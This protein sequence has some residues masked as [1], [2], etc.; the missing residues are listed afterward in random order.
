MK[1]RKNKFL[2]SI[3][4][5]LLVFLFLNSTAWYRLKLADYYWD[6]KNYLKSA[7]LYEKVFR[8]NR[9]LSSSNRVYGRDLKLIGYRS[10]IQYQKKG[11]LSKAKNIFFFISE[12]DQDYKDIKLRM[13]QINL[14]KA[15]ELLLQEEYMQAFKKV[16]YNTGLIDE[17]DK[18]VNLLILAVSYAKLGDWPQAVESF[19]KIFKR[20]P[21]QFYSDDKYLNKQAK[22]LMLKDILHPVLIDNFDVLEK[23]TYHEIKEMLN[24]KDIDIKYT[25]PKSWIPSFLDVV[26]KSA[27]IESG[28]YS[29]IILKG[30]DISKNKRGFNIAVLSSDDGRVKDIKTFDTYANSKDADRM[31]VFIDSL[32]EGDIFI[33]S[34]RDDGSCR[35]DGELVQALRRVGAKRDIRTHLRWAYVIVGKKG[36]PEGEALEELSLAPVEIDLSEDRII[37]LAVEKYVEDINIGN[38]PCILSYGRALDSRVVMLNFDFLE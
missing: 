10:A 6:R 7:I 31:R 14:A 21:L 20:I 24:V 17:D 30:V 4:G 22:E 38:K 33:A 11:K 37:N 23:L 35:V 15:K 27:G 25:L 5:L 34:V 3:F 13:A 8:K 32:S 16:V 26:V 18:L 1:T 28:N 12:M 19:E 36:L 2:G 29:H 9:I